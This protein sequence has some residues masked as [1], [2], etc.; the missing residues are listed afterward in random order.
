[1]KPYNH[2]KTLVF[3]LALLCPAL[4]G[5]AQN[6]NPKEPKADTLR[7][8][9]T[10]VTD[11][12]INMDQQ[13]AMP[14][15]FRIKQPTIPPFVAKIENPPSIAYVPYTI[16]LGQSLN[17]MAGQFDYSNK[18][19]FINLAAGLMYNLRGDVGYRAINKPQNTFDILISNRSTAAD[20]NTRIPLLQTNAKD[21][22]TKF[23]VDYRQLTDDIDF[24]LK[25]SYNHHMYNYYGIDMEAN[26]SENKFVS[27]NEN[28]LHRTSLELNLA[29]VQ[30]EDS[31]Y[32]YQGDIAYSYLARSS[33]F[34][35]EFPT[36]YEHA[37]HAHVNVNMLL[38]SNVKVGADGRFDVLSCDAN[39]PIFTS[40]EDGLNKLGLF[41]NAY[42]YLSYNNG[43]D[44]L[45]FNVTLGAGISFHTRNNTRM[46]FWPKLD[47]SLS[48]GEY[49]SLAAGVGGEVKPNSLQETL[50]DMP[51]LLPNFALLPSYEKLNGYAMLKGIIS[52]S[53]AVKLYGKYQQSE[54]L[55]SFRPIKESLKDAS[56]I[57]FMPYYSNATIY[58]FGGE[59]GYNLSG[60]LNISLGGQYHLINQPKEEH[61]GN[62][63][64]FEGNVQIETSLND[65][66]SLMARY[67]MQI[68]RKSYNLQKE[69]V[70]LVDVQTIVARANYNFNPTFSLYL[71]GSYQF[72]NNAERFWGYSYQPFILMAG[73]NVNF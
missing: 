66:L 48:F 8:E 14:I 52:S 7:R 13:Q 49:W 64:T 3:S 40:Q 37:A 10:V 36:T 62:I 27:N 53:V 17:P 9:L 61:I 30:K 56:Q 42:P 45:F 26:K 21:F 35:N 23:N 69:F 60:L 46:F 19:G 33:K 29:S 31:R 65:K 44:N 47:A 71:D 25:A 54:N 11:R 63:P 18:R 34:N 68:G 67:N 50:Q 57:A 20:V 41:L 2:I 73:L 38:S 51:F 5:Y 24:G 1:M 6:P 32:M 4:G 55:A 58:T 43:D 16:P 72:K 15:D 70:D 12:E 59:L 22:N 28:T 39:K